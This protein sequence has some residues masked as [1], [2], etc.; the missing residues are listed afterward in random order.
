[1]QINK[2]SSNSTAPVFGAKLVIK[3]GM[4]SQYQIKMRSQQ[5]YKKIVHLQIKRLTELVV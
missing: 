3:K 1:M 2:I 4:F 5:H